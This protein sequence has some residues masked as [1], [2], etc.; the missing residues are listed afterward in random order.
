MLNRKSPTFSTCGGDVM[1]FFRNASKRVKKSS[2]S[3]N[4]CVCSLERARPKRCTSACSRKKRTKSRD[5]KMFDVP[6]IKN[7]LSITLSGATWMALMATQFAPL[8]FKKIHHT[9]KSLFYSYF[10]SFVDVI[11]ASTKL[12]TCKSNHHLLVY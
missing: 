2:T 9:E 4:G 6:E 3:K 1:R 7:Y 8:Q 5:Q 10:L 12:L 11:T